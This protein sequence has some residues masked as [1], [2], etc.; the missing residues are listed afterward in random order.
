[1]RLSHI[2]RRFGA[3]VAVDDVS[4]DLAPGEIVGLVGENGAGKTTLMSIAAGELAADEG[5]IE[6]RLAAG[7]V[8][9][10]FLLVSEFTIAENL[11]LAMWGRNAEEII[12]DSGIELRNVNRRVGDL[13]VGEKAKL[14]LI[15]AIARH[16]PVLILDE[17]TSVLA[18]TEARELFDVMRRLAA[19]GTAVIFISHKIPEV[20][21]VATRIVVM[22][23]GKIVVDGGV[24]SA[25]ELAEAMVERRE[26]AAVKRRPDV[27]RSDS[28]VQPALARASR[29]GS[30]PSTGRTGESDLRIAGLHV[31]RGEIVAIIGVA[32]N[33]Q[34]ELAASLRD[35]LR[36][37]VAHIPEDRARDGLIAQMTI[38]ENIALA[39]P[40]WRPREATQRAAALIERFNIRAQSPLQRAG[41]LS[42]GNQQ[43]VILARELERQ[44]EIIVAAEPTRGLDIESTRFI[45]DEL[46]AAAGR[47]AAILLITSD[48]DEA[49]ALGDAIH[50]IYRGTL[51][52]RLTPSDAADQAPM[53]MAG[54]GP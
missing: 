4:L 35:S 42:G 6:D 50:V 49:F 21:E 16:P 38:A 3:N 36:G 7:V 52:A 44:P 48:L 15:K 9:Q 29:T 2:T 47:G 53:L 39:E 25:G 11:A 26:L 43:K 19:A 31:H 54:I 5:T 10:H 34:S 8:H 22:R 30:L 14:E 13:S 45:H 17:P 1:M 40:L 18:P 32:G 24:M 37:R 51:S 12:R 46:R 33:G 23:R 28:L 20:L 27:R 41:S